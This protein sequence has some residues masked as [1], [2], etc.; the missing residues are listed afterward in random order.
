MAEVKQSWR[1]D[2]VSAIA[3]HP[4]RAGCW[5]ILVERPA[6]PSEIAAELG[7]ELGIVSY[8]VRALRDLGVIELVDTRDRRGS[9]EHFYRAIERPRIDEA[10]TAQLTVEERNE[11]ARHILQRAFADAAFAAHAGTM[12]ARPD[13][14][15]SRTPLSVDEEGWR[16]LSAAY[17]E[18]LRRTI[19]AQAASV[20]RMRDSDEQP[21]PVSAVA[22]FFGTPKRKQTYPET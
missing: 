8:H 18:L 21:I 1:T 13:L 5:T 19:D 3:G 7:E 11:F 6:S 20:E 2:S 16:E 14:F 15:L 12:C 22:W 10:E 9:V 4:V 17:E